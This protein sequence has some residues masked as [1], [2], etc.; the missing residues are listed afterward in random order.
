MSERFN[1]LLIG[2]EEKYLVSIQTVLESLY[3]KGITFSVIIAKTI[4]EAT[5]RLAKEEKYDLILTDLYLSDS[6]EL[7]II[8]TLQAT[9]PNIPIITTSFHTDEKIIR[10][11]IRLGAQDYL[12]K[13][14]LDPKHLQRVIYASIE[15]NRLQQTLKTLSFTDE[16]TGLYNR[17]GFFTLLKQQVFLSKTNN[18]S[19]YFFL[20]DLDYLKMIN[21]TY[22][23]PAG[24][25]ALIDTAKLLRLSF[26]HHD[27]IGRIGGDEFGI[28]VTNTKAHQELKIKKKINDTFAKQNKKDKTPYQLTISIGFAY[29]KESSEISIKELVKIADQCLYKEKEKKHPKR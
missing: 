20:I 28:I 16:M 17:R 14:E 22:G 18:Q 10:K 24:D 9:N 11:I 2:D 6:K 4:K 26:R 8:K 29:F 12:P 21:D 27:I 19:F 7:Q 25:Q 13:K 1:L 15:R 23:H 3:I 5:S